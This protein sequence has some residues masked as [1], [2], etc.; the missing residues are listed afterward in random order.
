MTPNISA[1]TTDVG[2]KVAVASSVQIRPAP[3]QDILRGKISA[4]HTDII[5]LQ[6]KKEQSLASDDQI[7]QLKKAKN[8]LTAAEQSLKEK[9]AAQARQT[10]K[11]Q[12]D[13]IILEQIK[14]K[15][16]EAAELLA[17]RPKPG[18]P[19]IDEEQPELHQ[20]I[21]DIALYGSGADERRRSNKIRT[22][23]TLAELTTELQ[24]LGF[25][26]YF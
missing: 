12:K 2:G 25:K 6:Q 21:M 15:H 18:R 5:Y 13:K 3:Q 7:A 1:R 8:E 10:R 23:Q 16:P 24:L 9:V 14:E 19:R 20:T 26:V 22:I 4:L 17:K 11:R